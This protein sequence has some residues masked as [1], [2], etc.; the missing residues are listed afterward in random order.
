MGVN[1]SHQDE[2]CVL[3]IKISSPCWTFSLV[4]FGGERLETSHL[5][6]SWHLGEGRRGSSRGMRLHPCLND[7]STVP[8]GSAF[9]GHCNG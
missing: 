9:Q 6:V 5:E 1:S 8:S 3:K 4:H 2:Y 7:E